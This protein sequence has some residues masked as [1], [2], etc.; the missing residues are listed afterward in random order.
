MIRTALVFAAGILVG[1]VIWPAL[2]HGTREAL[3]AAP[4]VVLDHLVALVTP[5]PSGP[6]LNRP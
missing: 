1:A 4:L 5:G 2:D 3:V 6:G